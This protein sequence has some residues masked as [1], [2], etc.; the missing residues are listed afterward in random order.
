MQKADVRIVAAVNDDLSQAVAQG[1]LR[2]DLLYRLAS[3]VVYVPMLKDR[4]EDLP[5]LIDFFLEKFG[6]EGEDLELDDAVSRKLL[7]HSWPG[8]VRELRS[9]IAAAVINARHRGSSTI[10]EED[11][12]PF[13]SSLLG[14]PA[15]PFNPLSELVDA[16]YA[17]KLNLENAE[18]ESR[19]MILKEIAKRE[20]GDTAAI[21]KLLDK[22]PDAVRTLYSRSRVQLGRNAVDLQD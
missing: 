4:P 3:Y 2:K 8:N 20:G 9:V 5:R 19:K 15:V 17:G 6:R 22:S 21:S 1:R 14:T 11:L 18:K 10:T 12:D 16:I 7:A 13:P